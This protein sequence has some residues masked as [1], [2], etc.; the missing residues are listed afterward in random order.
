MFNDPQLSICLLQFLIGVSKVKKLE[1]SCATILLN[2]ENVIHSFQSN[3]VAFSELLRNSFP[4]LQ[5]NDKGCQSLLIKSRLYQSLIERISDS[6]YNNCQLSE[7]WTSILFLISDFSLFDQDKLFKLII[8]PS[9]LVLNPE[10]IQKY[11]VFLIQSNSTEYSPFLIHILPFTSNP[12]ELYQLFLQSQNSQF[13]NFVSKL[14]SFNY[15]SFRHAVKNHETMGIF[16]DILTDFTF[17][18][19]N[20]ES[21]IYSNIEMQTS[22]S[23]AEK[24]Q[25]IESFN[26]TMSPEDLQIFDL[27]RQYET[28]NIY[29]GDFILFFGQSAIN[30]YN[31]IGVNGELI[32]LKS[33]I[34]SLDFKLMRQTC[35]MAPYTVHSDSRIFLYNPDFLVQ[36]IQLVLK[37]VSQL[38]NIDDSFIQLFVESYCLSFLCVSLCSP[39]EQTRLVASHALRL[40]KDLLDSHD[41]SQFLFT[42]VGLDLLRNLSTDSTFIIPSFFGHFFAKSFIVLQEPAHLMFPWVCKFFLK[43]PC[44]ATESIGFFMELF[45][46]NE[47]ICRIWFLELLCDGLKDEESFRL[48][49]YKRIIQFCMNGIDSYHLYLD[50]VHREQYFRIIGNAAEIS[51]IELISFNGILGWIHVQLVS[52]KEKAHFSTAVDLLQL[53]L[54]ILQHLGRN[55]LFKGDLT[56]LDQF[57]LILSEAIK[58]E[59]FKILSEMLIVLQK[60][61]HLNVNPELLQNI[62]ISN[63]SF[64]FLMQLFWI[65]ANNLNEKNKLL[66]D[67]Y[68]RLS[69]TK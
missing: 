27:I 15:E 18:K 20:N 1:Q 7:A 22:L 37:K 63:N 52:S 12:F 64:Q 59:E 23:D 69:F 38:Q 39:N 25:I 16:K 26:G 50:S 14:I 28:K 8:F 41:T 34:S 53:T 58:L 17:E 40:F 21:I 65:Y 46:S 42:S 35:N 5:G 10:F 43:K 3:R 60:F 56:I 32:S 11:V 33:S 68:F 30:N 45:H 29:F 24:I 54:K 19:I 13:E 55:S 49:Q 2:D 66:D 57:L 6:L 4:F 67:I 51:P 61:K 47:K 9:E 36:W 44:L 31:Q 48:Y 62:S